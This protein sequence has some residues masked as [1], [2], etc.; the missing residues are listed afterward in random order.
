MNWLSRLCIW[1][2]WSSHEVFPL[3]VSLSVSF[4]NILSSS[5]SFLMHQLSLSYMLF[6]FLLHSVQLSRESSDWTD[7][8]KTSENAKEKKK[9]IIPLVSIKFQYFSFFAVYFLL[10]WSVCIEYVRL[11][12]FLELDRYREWVSEWGEGGTWVAHEWLTGFQG[13]GLSHV[14]CSLALSD[15]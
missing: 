1:S 13:R 15:L 14:L 3:S 10:T 4:S 11:V 5:M 2:S 9:I 6:R 12:D 7:V 8:N